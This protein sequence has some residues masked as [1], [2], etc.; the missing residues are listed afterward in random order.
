[1]VNIAIIGGGFFG[2]SIALKLKEYF[3][4]FNVSIYEKKGDLLEGT[5]GKNQFRCHRGYHYPRSIKTF[6]ECKA[7][8]NSFENFYHSSFIKSN[9]YYSIS[10]KKSKTNFEEYLKYLDKVN[11]K[12][13]ITSHPLIKNEMS[14]GIIKV[15]EKIIDI[16]KARRH[17]KKK[18]INIGVNINLNYEVELNNSFCKKNDLIILATYENNNLLK[19]Q[20][21]FN[22]D[23]YYF[24][25]V[26]KIIVDTPKSYKNFSCVVLDGDFVSIDPYGQNHI[27]GH[28]TKSDIRHENTNKYM[29]LNIKEKKL[30][31]QYYTNALEHSRYPAIKKDFQKFFNDFENTKYLKSFFVMR[32]TK[33]NN[34]DERTTSVEYIDKFISVHSGKWIN[35][36]EAAESICKFLK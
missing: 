15:N 32:C 27:I 30:I 5:S 23:K 4:N 17:I 18:L 26:E 14:E 25:L 19:C 6:M 16:Q 34:E 12:Y 35:C 1:M 36:I 9:N 31:D 29:K 28:V 20:M 11:L 10:K 33:K 13:E 3:N 22:T 7:S 8:L 2:T 24:Q 21:K